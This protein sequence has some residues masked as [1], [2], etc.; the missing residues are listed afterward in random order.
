MVKIIKKTAVRYMKPP[1]VESWEFLQDIAAE[2]GMQY[3][4][5][6]SDPRGL[7]ELVECYHSSD[8]YLDV[9]RVIGK[10]K[11]FTTYW[12]E[13][14]PGIGLSLKESAT[15]DSSKVEHREIG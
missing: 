14:E 15:F 12:V 7:E 10:S 1:H 2:N 8:H 5:S 9:I 6:R 11:E 13:S 4:L 3:L